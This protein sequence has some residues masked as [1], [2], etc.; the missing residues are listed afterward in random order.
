MLRTPRLPSVILVK[1]KVRSAK[2]LQRWKA[3][4]GH[5]HEPTAVEV[6]LAFVEPVVADAHHHDLFGVSSITWALVTERI[7][8]WVQVAFCSSALLS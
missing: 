2:P 1:V 3:M 4:P 6:E 7:R 8:G 5:R